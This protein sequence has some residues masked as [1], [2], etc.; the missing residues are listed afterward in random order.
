V[1]EADESSRTIFVLV[2]PKRTLTSYE[3]RECMMHASN[4]AAGD[5]GIVRLKIK[6]DD[7]VRSKFVEFSRIC[8]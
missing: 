5:S 4:N 8:R 3:H 2:G 7:V 1:R 6:Y